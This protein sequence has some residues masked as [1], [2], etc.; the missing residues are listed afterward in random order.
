MTENPSA[1]TTTNQKWKENKTSHDLKKPQET[2]VCLTPA[3]TP[4]QQIHKTKQS[5][6]QQSKGKV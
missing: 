5:K 2:Q 6:A 4:L 1:K 3:E